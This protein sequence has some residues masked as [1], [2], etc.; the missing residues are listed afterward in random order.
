MILSCFGFRMLVGY[1]MPVPLRV[2]RINSPTNHFAARCPFAP[3]KFKIIRCKNW[4]GRLRSNGEDNPWRPQ[5][6]T[7]APAAIDRGEHVCF[8]ADHRQQLAAMA[9]TARDWGFVRAEC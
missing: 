4:R 6:G 2:Q 5:C 7:L 9:R 8:A 1:F 3:F